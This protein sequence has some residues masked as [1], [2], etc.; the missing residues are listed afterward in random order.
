MR[1]LV[2][3]FGRSDLLDAPG[4]H[5]DDAIGHGHRL[6]LVVRDID[7]RVVEFVVQAADF[8]AHVAAKIRI[9]I[10]Q[11]LI[12]QKN[13]GLGRQ[14][15]RQ[16]DALLLTA[17]QFRGIALGLREE[18]RGVEQDVGTGLPLRRRHRFHFQAVADI[19]PNR[20]VRPH[21][22]ALEDHAHVAPLGRND[23]LDR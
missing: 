19:L 12:Q 22:V 5:D 3:V 13:V 2:D 7:R 10:G 15:P 9:E 18:L 8:E 16:R 1:T 20:H 23:G 21:G 17:G 14:R 11:R 4:V 6:D